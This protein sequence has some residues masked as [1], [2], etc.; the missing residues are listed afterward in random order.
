MLNRT[1]PADWSAAWRPGAAPLPEDV[2]FRG[3]CQWRLPDCAD[4]AL[5]V[6]A[7]R[8]VFFLIDFGYLSKIVLIV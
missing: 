2:E 8:F 6:V 4:F 5:V 1:L 7:E 3:W